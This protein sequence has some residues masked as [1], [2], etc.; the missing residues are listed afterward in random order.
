MKI[1]INITNTSKSV[2]V[3]ENCNMKEF[4]EFMQTSF[5][6]C[7]EEFQVSTQN[8]IN[9]SSP[10]YVDRYVPYW[11]Q[12]WWGYTGGTVNL[13]N[14]LTYSNSNSNSIPAAGNTI[15]YNAS[16]LHPGTYNVEW[17]SSIHKSSVSTGL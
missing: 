17:D 2:S 5:P 8:I 7:W 15:V 10:I 4:V 1:Q 3:E 16:N 14:T 13:G 12:P 9:Y 11:R 6:T